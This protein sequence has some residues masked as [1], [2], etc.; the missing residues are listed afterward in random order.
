MPVSNFLSEN[1][2]SEFCRYHKS[3]MEMCDRHKVLYLYGNGRYA[4]VMRDYMEHMDIAITGNCI[5]GIPGVNEKAVCVMDL[6]GD[7]CSNA[8]FVFAVKEEYQEKIKTSLISKNI[9]LDILSLPDKFYQV[10]RD[11]LTF[12]RK[13]KRFETVHK[14]ERDIPLSVYAEIEQKAQEVRSKRWIVLQRQYGMGDAFYLEPVAR[15]L[16]DMGYAVFISTDYGFVF[17]NASYLTDIFAFNCVPQWIL[18]RAF[19]IDF[20]NA[21]ERRPFMHILDAYVKQIQEVLPGFTLEEERRIPI[22]DASMIRERDKTEIK[23]ICVNFEAS[24]WKS[25]MF[26]RSKTMEIIKAL[27]DRGIEIYEIGCNEDYYLGV[28]KNC[29]GLRF[30]ETIRLMSQMDL[31]IGVD[32]GLMHFA[33]SVHLPIFILFGCTCP[34]YRV[35]DWS[36]AR[37]MWKSAKELICS[38]C[39]HR[40]KIP[41]NYTYCGRD[42]HYCM[43][44]TADEVLNAFDTLAYDMPP[45]IG[46]ADQTPIC[47]TDKEWHDR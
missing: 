34:M 1:S 13:M 21:Y 3:L 47:W 6:S 10:C 38:G 33:Q 7:E 12:V 24:E 26:P 25:R 29:Y 14:K 41:Q 43:D 28:G 5:S 35:I 23:K 44:W 18:D 8:G 30:P 46:E 11:Y 22:Y 36:N 4:E 37:V 15:K 39:H 32:N 42:K 16:S 45:E 17:E 2:Y 40:V 20:F 9:E 19:L 31:F 27:S